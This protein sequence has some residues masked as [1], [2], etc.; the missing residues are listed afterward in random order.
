MITRWFTGGRELAFAMGLVLSMSRLGD[1]IALTWTPSIADGLFGGNFIY[2]LWI[3]AFLCGVSLIS[4]I[5]YSL[6]DKA[7]EKY[8]VGR[9]INPEENALNFKAVL[10]FDTRFWLVAFICMTYYGGIF[11]FVSI[12][13]D[14]LRDEYKMTNKTEIAQ[15]SGLITL[16]SMILSP[17]LGKFL[18]IVAR[19]P[20]FVA[21]GSLI[22]IPCHL[23]LAMLIPYPEIPIIFIGLSFSLV[24]SALWPSIPLLVQPSE[25]A[26][27]FGVMAAIQN[28]GLASINALS[29]VIEKSRFGLRG[30][31]GFFV[32]MDV[33]GLTLALILIIVDTRKGRT[34]ITPH[35]KTPIEAAPIVAAN[36]GAGG[37]INY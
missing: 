6:V 29:T 24:P 22:V 19:R 12:C 1:Y 33:V 15:L 23:W 11:P 13:S 30:A 18:D 3:G 37:A 34:L 2:I 20:Y 9:T 36:E 16:A 31:I 25:V 26:T 27:A 32:L 35:R 17:F 4:V 14:Y 28:S 21:L 5:V 7:T 8:F 10:K